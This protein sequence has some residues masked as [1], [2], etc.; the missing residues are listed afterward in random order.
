MTDQVMSIMFMA[1]L[2]VCSL[3]ALFD[4][5]DKEDE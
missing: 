4:W 1:L 5:V 2:L 3:I